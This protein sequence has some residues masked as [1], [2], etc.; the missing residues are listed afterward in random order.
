MIYLLILIFIP[1]F[2]VGAVIYVST[3]YEF[4]MNGELDMILLLIG[5]FASLISSFII[6]KEMSLLEIRDYKI[7]KFQRIIDGIIGVLSFTFLLLFGIALII[8]SSVISI[9][10]TKMLVGIAIIIFYIYVIYYYIFRKDIYVFKLISITKIKDKLYLYQFE[11]K[12][13]GL[14]DFYLDNKEKYKKNKSYKVSFSK[15][16]NNISKILG[17][18]I[19]V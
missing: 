1:I 5:V 16:N 11:N 18:V 3:I 14:Q 2:F 17:E 15:A 10:Y 13:Q 12:E 19:E 6:F 9:N 4:A 7:I 8:N